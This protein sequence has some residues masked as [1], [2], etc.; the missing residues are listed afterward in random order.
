MQH[1]MGNFMQQKKHSKRVWRRNKK[2]KK[3]HLLNGVEFFV[4]KHQNKNELQK[5]YIIVLIL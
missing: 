1:L 4:L 2:Q 5:L 3:I